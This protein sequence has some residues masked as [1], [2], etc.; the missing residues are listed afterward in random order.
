MAKIYRL[1][2][3][4]EDTVEQKKTQEQSDVFTE[5]MIRA[6]TFSFIYPMPPPKKSMRQGGSKRG[7]ARHIANGDT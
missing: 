5:F 7:T 6:C 3:N 1:N 2:R 4:F